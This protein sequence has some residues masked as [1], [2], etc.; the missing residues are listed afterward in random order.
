MHQPQ[1]HSVSQSP[2]VENDKASGVSEPGCRLNICVPS[3]NPT[4][5]CSQSR[6]FAG[7]LFPRAVSRAKSARDFFLLHYTMSSEDLLLPAAQATADEHGL[8]FSATS[9]PPAAELFGCF[10]ALPAQPHATHVPYHNILWSSGD[11]STQQITYVEPHGHGLRV[12]HATVA[13]PPGCDVMAHAYRH[14]QRAPAILVVV[15]NHG[16]VGRARERYH[17]HILPVLQAARCSVTYVETKYA[18]HA[19]D[20]GRELDVDRYDIVACCLGDG[21]PHEIINGM[22]ERRDRARAFAR[23]AVTQLPCGLGNALLWSTHGSGDAAVAAHRMLKLAR[24]RMDVMAVTQGDRTRLSFLSQAYGVIADLDIGTEHLRWMGAVRFEVGVAQRVWQ[25]ARYP[26]D[27]WVKYAAR[28]A[29]VGRHYARAR[30]GTVGGAD[31]GGCAEDGSG[32]DAESGADA[33]SGGEAARAD[34]FV[35]AGPPLRSP[36]PRDWEQVPADDLSIFYVGKMPYM[37]TDAQFFPA[38]L[39]RDGLMDMVITST[40]T[41]FFKMVRVLL[42]VDKGAHVHSPEVHHAKIAAYRLVPRVDPRR[43]FLSVDGES[44]PLEPLQVEVLPELLTVLLPK[45]EYVDTQFA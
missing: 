23:V 8:Y 44:F 28:G 38:A 3:Q 7:G 17:R 42:A 27:L 2:N 16:G 20:M 26:C 4:C 24:S 15:N 25:K 18:R 9:A 30:K 39:P 13:V 43:H 10:S 36:P 14:S 34:P 21:V 12:A 11:G 33:G 6:G 35:P 1:H 41:L 31:A 19:V 22:Y 40:A 5:L 32:A 45:G 37:L 29:D